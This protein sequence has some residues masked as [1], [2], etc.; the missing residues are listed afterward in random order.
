MRWLAWMVPHA[1]LL[2]LLAGHAHAANRWIAA[3]SSNL[4][5]DVDNWSEGVA[6][7]S[8][9]VN[10]SNGWDDPAGPFYPL[11]PDPS[12]DF[13]RFVN[14]AQLTEEGT[15]T[16][17]DSSV[18]DAVTYGL[19]VGFDGATNDLLMTGGSLTVGE[20][21]LNIGRV[22]NRTNNPN[23]VATMRM[24]GG[25]I[26]AALVKIPEQFVD[27]AQLDPYDSAPL[28][29]ELYMSGGVLNARKINVGQ[30]TGSGEAYFSGDAQINL[31]PNVPGDPG[32]GGY[33]EMKQDWFIDG[34]PVPTTADAYIDISEDAIFTITGHSEM[35]IVSPDASEVARYQG[36]VDAH[37]LTAW[38]GTASPVITLDTTTGPSPFITIEAPTVPGDYN[39]NGVVDAADYTLFRDNEGAS[40]TLNGENPA[41]ATP[42]VVDQEDY[43]FWEANFGT[44]AADLFPLPPLP[45]T[46][47][48]EPASSGGL[49]LL[50]ALAHLTD[51]RRCRSAIA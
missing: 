23:P 40:I 22:F 36:Y 7:P 9:T 13:P 27:P 44:T 37:E 35:L 32:N 4:W 30:F 31:S 10:P 50:V 42:G 15:T 29:G 48:P 3:G 18:T 34:L 14:E 11:T 45:G 38:G 46:A 28:H 19:Y 1:L 25:T 49:L 43:D 20:W 41:A 51:R 8:A 47:V 17:I 2:V 39:N 33:L 6:P 5:T 16:L 24:T 12:D 26:N 21:H